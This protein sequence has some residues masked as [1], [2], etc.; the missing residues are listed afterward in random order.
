MNSLVY[1]IPIAIGLAAL[2]LAA[3]LWSLKSGQY[4]DLEGSAQRI[5]LEEDEMLGQAPS[6]EKRRDGGDA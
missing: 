6:Q 5:L 2:G 4:D 3:F 1:M